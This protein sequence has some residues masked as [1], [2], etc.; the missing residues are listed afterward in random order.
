LIP[1]PEGRIKLAYVHDPPGKPTIETRWRDP[2][3]LAERGFTDV[4]VADQLSG[5]LSLTMENA[6]L[7]VAGP[8]FEELGQRVRENLDAGLRPWVMEDLF[9]LSKEDAKSSGGCPFDDDL[10]RAIATNIQSLFHRLPDLEGIIFRFGEAFETHPWAS[11]VSPFQCECALCQRRGK[12]GAVSRMVSELEEL[13]CNELGMRCILRLWDLGDDGIHADS[14]QQSAAL[15]SW[16]ENSRLVVSVK[17]SATDYWRHQPWNESIQLDGPPRIL[18]FQCEREYEFLGMV[19]NWL[20]HHWANGFPECDE[21][22]RAGLA[23]CRP[24]DWAGSYIIPRGGGWSAEHATDDFWSEMNA[25]AIIALTDDPGTD[26]SGI[27]DEFLK[28]SGFDGENSRD[29]FAALIEKSSE[30]VLHL[31]YLPTYHD[32]T[33]QLWMPSN[34]WFR[35]DTFVPGACAD[36]ANL[37][38]SAGRADL[39]RSE[40]A[41]ATIF[42][43]NQLATAES[44][45]AAGNPLA[46]HKRGYFILDSYRWAHNFA[47]LT[48]QLWRRLLDAAPLNRADAKR[49]IS[50]TLGET[51][52]APL[53]CLD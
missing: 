11:R 43:K 45:F 52:L 18:E 12:V 40:R 32:L 5:C 38:T 33:N 7:E 24:Q 42:S 16:N 47:T 1:R 48:E 50:D 17:H 31:R 27:L 20:G 22:G 10:W 46:D 49:I 9:T 26:P 41:F 30:L 25:H 39:L 14:E 37:V 19:P 23:N 6:D 21:V 29:A 8:I 13:I 34:N 36:V 2:T 44:L 4:V 15:A 3:F 28:M 53:K 35:D 51:P